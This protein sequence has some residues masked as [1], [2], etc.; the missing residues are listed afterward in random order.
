MYYISSFIT[1][2]Y[3]HKNNEYFNELTQDLPEEA[4]A[5]L[6]AVYYLGIIQQVHR[7]IT[8]RL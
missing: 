7:L 2:F 8:N 1:N 6:Q 5:Y 4:K 3:L